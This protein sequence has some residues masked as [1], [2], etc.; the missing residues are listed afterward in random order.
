MKNFQSLTKHYC[1]YFFSW[2]ITTEHYRRS[3]KRTASKEQCR[4]FIIRA[5]DESTLFYL[6]SN[7]IQSTSQFLL[8]WYI[9]NHEDAEH[10]AD[11][12][13]SYK[14]GIFIQ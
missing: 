1:C 8:Q 9:L 5:A 12:E 2:K 13:K 10:V 4:L 14:D 11:N 6:G 3:Q 7:F